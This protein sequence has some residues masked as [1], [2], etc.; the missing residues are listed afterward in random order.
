MKKSID[1]LNGSMERMIRAITKSTDIKS[2]SI[3]TRGFNT[4]VN[5]NRYDPKKRRTTYT[6]NQSLQLKIK[7]R[8]EDIIH[9]LN[10]ITE[11]NSNANVQ[12]SSYF[13]NQKK[14]E[15]EEQLINGAFDN[16]RHQA[17]MLA[18]AGNFTVGNVRSVNYMQS[19]PFQVRANYRL[20]A[21]QMQADEEHSFGDFNLAGQRIS[22]RIDISFYIY[23]KEN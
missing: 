8:S 15:V 11:S 3:K 22:K 6:A 5:D 4:Y 13:S 17:N 1:S 18:K 12:T 2:D 7:A 23:P 10:V 19:T 14:A 20:E 16:A 21:A 9:L